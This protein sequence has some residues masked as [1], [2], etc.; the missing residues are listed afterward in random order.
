M[1]VLY[2]VAFSCLSTS[3]VSLVVAS[4]LD[5]YLA[6]PGRAIQCLALGFVAVE[7]DHKRLEWNSYIRAAHYTISDLINCLFLYYCDTMPFT[8]PMGI[9]VPS[10]PPLPPSSPKA[11]VVATTTPQKTKEKKRLKP[12]VTAMVVTT[13][14]GGGTGGNSSSNV[15]LPPATIVFA[16]ASTKAAAAAAVDTVKLTPSTAIEEEEDKDGRGVMD[17]TANQKNST[18]SSEYFKC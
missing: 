6:V 12:K 14:G 18:K 17:K 10:P 15:T 2:I 1:D 7:E 9:V 16:K 11:L 5:C 13:S 8:R 3:R 4:T